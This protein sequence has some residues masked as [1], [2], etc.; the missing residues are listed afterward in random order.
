MRIIRKK[1]G[2]SQNVIF[3]F[4]LRDNRHPLAW[5]CDSRKTCD[6]LS[7]TVPLSYKHSYVLLTL[8]VAVLAVAAKVVFCLVL[9]T[10]LGQSKAGQLCTTT[11]NTVSFCRHCDGEVVMHVL[12]TNGHLIFITRLLS[13]GKIQ[14]FLR[15]FYTKRYIVDAKGWLYVWEVFRCLT[16]KLMTHKQV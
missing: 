11:H 7:R 14:A 13:M 8:K 6:D 10:A 1:R 16:R 9:V 12:S 2:K 4:T 5:S 15:T 3:A